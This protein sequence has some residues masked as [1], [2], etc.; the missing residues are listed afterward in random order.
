MI[1]YLLD[2]SAFIY[3]IE[4][5][6]KLKQNFFLEKAKGNAFLYMPQFCVTEVFNAYARLFFR[7]NKIDS[8]RYN[9]WRNEFI[10]AVR[11]RNLIY[12]YDLHR[13][14]NINTDK[15]FRLEHTTPYTG[16]ERALSGFDILIIGMGMEL[17]LL[18]SPA[19]VK[20]LSRD[21]RLIRIS[22]LNSN[23][24]PAIWLD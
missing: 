20:I 6:P 14:H 24:A 23:F 5:L 4:N 15:I 2:V 9:Q 1:Y 19:E 22:N 8:S 18:H 21:R 10:K 12:C 16:N 13:Y 11:N 17:K 7:D 3:A